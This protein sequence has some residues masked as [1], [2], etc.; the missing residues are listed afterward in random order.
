[1]MRGLD[2]LEMVRDGP[3]SLLELSEN[4]G[5]TRST[6]HRLAAA[7]VE[8]QYLSFTPRRGYSLGP[9]ILAL[10]H[11]ARTQIQLARVARPI[12]EDLAKQ[13]DDIVHLGVIEG[14]E[15]L[16]LEKVPQK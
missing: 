11:C 1:M 12:L 2:V 3:V 8:R 5:L 14:D 15:V 16:Y 10:G 6:A 4:L 9:L 13:T 7:L